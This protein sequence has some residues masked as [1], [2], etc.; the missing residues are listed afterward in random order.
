MRVKE[1]L[2]KGDKRTRA[3]K[4]I[5]L[6]V[7]IIKHEH[8]KQEAEKTMQKQVKDIIGIDK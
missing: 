8:G 3:Y 5:K 1:F 7:E 6:Y 4:D 2:Q